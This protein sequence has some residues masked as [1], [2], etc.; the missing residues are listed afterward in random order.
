[1]R[2]NPT[3]SAGQRSLPLGRAQQFPQFRKFLGLALLLI[4]GGCELPRSEFSN[5][6]VAGQVTWRNQPL[7]DAW[8]VFI[9]LY[10]EVRDGVLLPIASGRTDENGHYRLLSN[11]NSIGAAPGH[12]RVMISKRLSDEPQHGNPESRSNLGRADRELLPDQFHSATQL[13]AEVPRQSRVTIDWHLNND[14][15]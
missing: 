1:M 4:F 12:Y 13:Q 14:V 3:D 7:A 9:P 10:P 2:Y 15:P 11:Q 5:C 8:V 6:E